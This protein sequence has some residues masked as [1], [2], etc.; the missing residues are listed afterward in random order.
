[1]SK[2]EQSQV[3][4]VKSEILTVQKQEVVM[5]DEVKVIKQKKFL[6]RKNLIGKGVIIEATFSKTN[7]V[8]KYSH[9]EAYAVL[10]D[11]L[12]AMNCWAKYSSYTSSTNLPVAVRHLEIK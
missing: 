6:L 7:R 5:S 8:I 9:D 11:K 10:A 3:E 2:V 4:A 1:M 12:N